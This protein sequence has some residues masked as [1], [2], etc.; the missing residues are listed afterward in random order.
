M[1]HNC[2]LTTFASLVHQQYSEALETSKL[3]ITRLA[4]LPVLGAT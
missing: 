3:L 1:P 4:A 2:A